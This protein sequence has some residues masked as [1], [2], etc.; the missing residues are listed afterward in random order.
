MKKLFLTALFLMSVSVFAEY[1]TWTTSINYDCSTQMC[2][3]YGNCYTNYKTCYM[4][5]YYTQSNGY[6][7]YH[8]N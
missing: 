4:T 5:C 2:N 3:G 6:V 7:S 8:C 1:R